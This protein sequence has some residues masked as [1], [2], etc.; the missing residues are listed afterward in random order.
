MSLIFEEKQLTN[1]WK[2][3][4]S[5]TD[6]PG[7]SKSQVSTSVKKRSMLQI[8]HNLE[9]KA[10]LYDQLK[11]GKSDLTPPDVMKLQGSHSSS[12][13]DNEQQDEEEEE[14]EEEEE[15]IDEFGRSRMVKVKAKTPKS[16]IYG[17]VIQSGAFSLGAA[18]RRAVAHEEKEQAEMDNGPIHFDSAWEQRDLG[19]AFYQFS[20]DQQLRQTQF[21]SLG[22]AVDSDHL[23]DRSPDLEARMAARVARIRQKRASL[24]DEKTTAA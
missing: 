3:S 10:K 6:M 24:A 17:N 16:L 20:G 14:E 8:R 12:G 7:A 18:K 4:K 13:E 19:V 2:Q 11:A 1:T 9:K 23:Q 21:N 15:I 22:V 5:A